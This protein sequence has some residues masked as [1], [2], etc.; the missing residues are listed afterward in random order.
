MRT[1]MFRRTEPEQAHGP[2]E[3][4]QTC[5]CWR[6]ALLIGSITGDTT[7]GF[8]LRC[9]GRM[10]D[11]IAEDR[12]CNGW[13][14][15]EVGLRR[16]DG[17]GAV[18]ALLSRSFELRVMADE[19]LP[20]LVHAHHAMVLLLRRQ[21]AGSPASASCPMASMGSRSGR[22][23]TPS[24]RMEMRRRNGPIKA[25]CIVNLQRQVYDR[26]RDAR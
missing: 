15:K 11:Q 14:R 20:A 16:R 19:R 26:Q 1:E 5:Q 13:N 10:I 4:S 2:A 22:P 25:P 17:A 6:T 24:S 12:R 8:C 18:R 7:L 21:H 9:P 3:R 23:N